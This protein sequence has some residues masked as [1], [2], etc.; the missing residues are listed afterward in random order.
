MKS[1]IKWDCT[2]TCSDSSS[3]PKVKELSLL[4]WWTKPAPSH[5]WLQWNNWTDLTP[6]NYHLPQRTK[7][8]NALFFFQCFLKSHLKCTAS[9]FQR[10]QFSYTKYTHLH[11]LPHTN[12]NRRGLIWNGDTDL[13]RRES[14]ENSKKLQKRRKKNKKSKITPLRL[15]LVTVQQH[16]CHNSGA[17]SCLLFYNG[18][19]KIYFSHEQG[20]GRSYYLLAFL[21]WIYLLESSLLFLL[22]GSTVKWLY[23][24]WHVKLGWLI[25][26]EDTHAQCSDFWHSPTSQIPPLLQLFPYAPTAPFSLSLS[27]NVSNRISVFYHIKAIYS[28][29]KVWQVFC[30]GHCRH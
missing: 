1:W 9:N 11:L 22:K 27:S 10:S 12:S 14:T 5:I 26:A 4:S 3:Y 20:P 24:C 16:H 21:M 8:A 15:K 30:V 23:I 18:H 6:T 28:K 13:P 2:Q 17:K 25:L 19:R 7:A 29:N